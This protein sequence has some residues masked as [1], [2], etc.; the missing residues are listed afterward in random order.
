MRILHVKGY[1]FTL[2]INWLSTNN[3]MKINWNTSIIQLLIQD[4]KVTL[5][6]QKMCPTLLHD[7]TT[8]DI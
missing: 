4:Q 8:F 3:P 6:S 2:G 5:K 1:D 7:T